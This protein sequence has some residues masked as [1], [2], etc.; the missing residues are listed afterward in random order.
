LDA[1]PDLVRP[2]LLLPSSSSSPDVVVDDATS[3]TTRRT[4]VLVIMNGLIETALLL[5]LSSSSDDNDNLLPNIQCLY[6]AMAFIC[7]N[8][9]GPATIEHSY[10]GLLA[11]GVAHGQRETRKDDEQAFFDLFHHSV[12]PVSIESNLYRGRWNK[13]LW[14]LPFNGISVAM[15]GITVDQIVHDPGLRQLARQI[16]EETVAVA[17]ASLLLQQEQ[18][19]QQEQIAAASSGRRR[20]RWSL[21]KVHCHGAIR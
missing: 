10:Y 2:L 8:R 13:M 5:A 12:V 4:R 16:M 1:I 20:S 17:N 11:A 19:E 9:I 7:A 14:N 21:S 6:T 15:G 18:Q 3:T